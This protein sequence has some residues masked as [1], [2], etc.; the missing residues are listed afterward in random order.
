MKIRDVFTPGKSPTV[1]FVD[2][3]IKE[4]GEQLKDALEDGSV[5]V[6][7]SG[8][9]KSGKTVFVENVIGKGCLVQVTG[10]GVTSPSDL[11][12]KVFD[13]I[14]TPVKRA[15]TKGTALSGS[16]SGKAAVEG[17]FVLAKATGEA[18]ASASISRSSSDTEETPIDLLQLL[19]KEL[20]NSGMIVFIDDFH[21]IP[22]HIQSDISNQIKEAIRL[23]VK[24]IVASVPYH[25]DD[26]IRSN[27]DL[28]GRIFSI[29][30]DYWGAEILKKIAF[31]GFKE[32]GV[33]YRQPTIDRLAKE[34]AGSPQLMQYL[35][36]NT[37]Y[38]IGLRESSNITIDFPHDEEIL[39]KICVRTVLSAD[40]SSVVARMLEGPKTRGSDRKIYIMHD[41]QQGDVYKLL[42]ASL[43]SDP[44]QLIFRYQN[45]LERIQGICSSDTPSGSSITS[46]CQH[47]TS[48]GNDTAGEKIMEWDS[49]HDVLD[50]R[51]PYLLFYLRWSEK[52]KVN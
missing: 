51:D 36:L 11:W 10:A 2:E 42:I 45:L 48:I 44:P 35:C 14:G 46:A 38:E 40:Y 15:V 5:L 23:G 7:I 19:I 52:P 47:S 25:S 29:D 20:G 33:G 50:I 34:A 21:Y 1:T 16:V 6:S 32:L 26:V 4:K 24:F 3:H 39:S 31:R 27:P 9:S 8:P 18:G 37:C 41:G 17:G 30:F 28:R 13:F 43:S 12:L 22:K 49:E